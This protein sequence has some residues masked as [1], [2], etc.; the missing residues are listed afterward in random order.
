MKISYK[1]NNNCLIKSAFIPFEPGTVCLITGIENPA[2]HILG[3]IIAKLFPID[4]KLPWPQ[5]Q[6]LIQ[7]YSG[8]VK[9]EESELPLSSAYVGNDPDRHLLFSKVNEELSVQIKN[10]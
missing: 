9:I 3:G 1:L 8:E 7:S 2:F 6:A 5:L 4:E 10:P